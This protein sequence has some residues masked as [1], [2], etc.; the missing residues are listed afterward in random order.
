[1]PKVFRGFGVYVDGIGV[2]VGVTGAVGLKFCGETEPLP[3]I[4][5]EPKPV[6]GLYGLLVFIGLYG[7]DILL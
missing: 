6:I 2:A 1:M 5:I 4:P 7:F 3:R